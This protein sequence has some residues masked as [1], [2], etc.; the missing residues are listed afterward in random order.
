MSGRAAAGLVAIF[1]LAGCAEM[2]PTTNALGITK[3]AQQVCLPVEQASGA[4]AT[5]RTIYQ[6]VAP[7][8]RQKCAN[9]TLSAE[10]CKAALEADM[11]LR[12]LNFEAER[13]LANPGVTVDWLR[14]NQ[15]LATLIGAA[16]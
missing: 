13:I 5:L 14:V 1:L 4:M 6:R 8:V 9:K 16:L 2:V 3:P 15:Y 7:V 11:A 12:Q 10:E